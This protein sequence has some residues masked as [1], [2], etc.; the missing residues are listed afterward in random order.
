MNSVTSGSFFEGYVV[1]SPPPKVAEDANDRVAPA[2]ILRCDDDLKRRKTEDVSEDV[3]P[4]QPQTPDA[5]NTFFMVVVVVVIVD[6]EAEPRIP[7]PKDDEPKDEDEDEPNIA[8]PVIEPN[9]R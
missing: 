8:E 9:A 2:W 1:V 5:H 7:S 4:T 6:A 3:S